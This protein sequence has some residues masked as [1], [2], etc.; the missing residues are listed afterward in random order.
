MTQQELSE[1]TGIST[2]LLSHYVNNRRIVS[3]ENAKLISDKL[4]CKMEELYQW[5][6]DGE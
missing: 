2:S 5:V 6:D 3:Y 4:S 1:R